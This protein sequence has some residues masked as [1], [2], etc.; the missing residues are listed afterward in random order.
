MAIKHPLTKVELLGVKNR[1][2]KE[3]LEKLQARLKYYQKTG[4]TYQAVKVQ[5]QIRA[6]EGQ[7]QARKLKMG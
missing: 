1:K 5:R 3:K 6:I 7:M 2:Q 4:E